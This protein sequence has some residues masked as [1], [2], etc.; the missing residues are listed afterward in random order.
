MRLDERR[1]DC[2]VRAFE[3]LARKIDWSTVDTGSA[4]ELEN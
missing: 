4:E 3:G 2:A 1:N